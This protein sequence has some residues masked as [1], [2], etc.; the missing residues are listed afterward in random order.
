MTAPAASPAFDLKT[1][2]RPR[3]WVALFLGCGIVVFVGLCVASA[4]PGGS[5]V[6]AQPQVV[7]TGNL[8]SIRLFAVAQMVAFGL[9]ATAL[10]V[11]RWNAPTTT[12]VLVLAAVIQLLPLAA[13]LMMSTDAWSYSNAGR[14][15]VVHGGNPFEDTPNAYPD[16]PTLPFIS[17]AWRDRTTVYGPVFIVGAEGIAAVAGDNTELAIWLYKAVSGVLMVALTM[18]VSR[19]A[20]RAAFA[21]AFVGWNPVFAMQF[22]GSGHNDIL[23]IALVMFGLALG[24]KAKVLEAGAAWSLAVFVKWIPLVLLPLQLLEDRARR[25][26]SIAPGFLI[27]SVLVAGLSTVLFGW[28]WMGAVSPIADSVTS[29]E[30]NSLAIWPRLSHWL[31]AAFVKFGPIVAFAIVY[32]LLLGQAWRGR[33]RRGLAMGLFLLASPYLFTW[34]VVTPAA[35]SAV[36]D[37]IPALWLAL[38][39]SAYTG[40]LY[41]G[42]V[43]SVFDVF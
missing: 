37:D 38:A 40:L 20:K 4:W 42:R 21:A 15:A 19:I 31:P 8:D 24:A 29:G 6:A 2:R 23:M 36:E 34:Y 39:L 7:R 3:H 14:I 33:A 30:I 41:L 1:Q 43:G 10:A 17:S 16:D 5:M 12:R 32:L 9:Y 25:R 26:R 11:V 35:L 27:G 13:P 28:S 22:A 18:V